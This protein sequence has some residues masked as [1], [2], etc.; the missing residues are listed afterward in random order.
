MSHSWRYLLA[1][2]GNAASENV[3][4]LS[5]VDDLEWYN[6]TSVTLPTTPTH[7]TDTTWNE[8]ASH[9]H[10]GNVVV[11]TDFARGWPYLN[12]G[13]DDFANEFPQGNMKAEYTEDQERVSVG[14]EN[15]M[16]PRKIDKSDTKPEHAPYIWHVKDEEPPEI[17]RRVQ[18]RMRPPYFYNEL[19]MNNA[20]MNQSFEVEQHD[21]TKSIKFI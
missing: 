20:I 1:L 11:V 17:K 21:C 9:V 15:W 12:W 2:A 3:F 6:L 13:C 10:D 4:P 19:R 18:G 8:F 5:G 7:L 16:K 14:D